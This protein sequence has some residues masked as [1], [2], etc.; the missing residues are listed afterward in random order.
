MKTNWSLW[1]AIV[2]TVLIVALI[3][4]GLVLVINYFT[5]PQN[6]RSE[7]VIGLIIVLGVSVLIVLLFIIAAG[8][9][10]LGMGDPKQ[11]MGLPEGSIRAMIALLLIIV[12]VI[13]S[14]FLFNAVQGQTGD[15]AVTRLAQQLFTTMA[16]L[17]VAIASFYF[18]S[19]SVAS[20]RAALAP[21]IPTTR[22]VIGRVD[23]SQVAQSTTGSLLTI[24]GKYFRLPKSVRLVQDSTTIEATEI[25]SSDTQIQCKVTIAA[26]QK[27]GKWDLIVVNEDGGQDRLAGAFEVITSEASAAPPAVA[28]APAP[29][30]PPEQPPTS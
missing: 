22:P 2:A 27:T 29:S 16:T 7:L 20:A 23:P 21:S 1:G 19:R 26:D 14:V 10:A 6:P 18:G 17:V 24:Q 12:W 11:A 28:S 3:I 25:I 13:L 8:F 4:T 30:V 9:S 5:T 15:T